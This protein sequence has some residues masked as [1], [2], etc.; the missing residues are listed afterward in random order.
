MTTNPYLYAVA[1]VSVSLSMPT[2][3]LVLELAGCDA[4][5]PGQLSALACY[6]GAD[7]CLLQQ[8]VV[9]YLNMFLFLFDRRLVRLA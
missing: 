8:H 7:Q 3:C 1:T 5:E 9:T 4:G 2:P 6:P